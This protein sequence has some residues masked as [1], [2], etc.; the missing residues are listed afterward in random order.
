MKKFNILTALTFGLC[1]FGAS[2][3]QAAESADIIVTVSLAESI[4]VE[5]DTTAWNIGPISLGSSHE[6]NAFTATNKGNV[7]ADIKIKATDGA[8]GWIIAD[9]PGQDAFKVEVDRENDGVYD[10]T[11]TTID[12]DLSTNVAPN[13]TVNFKVKYSAPTSNTKPVGDDQGFKITITASKTP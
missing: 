13:N 4:S 10:L 7:N 11:L 8:G 1:L 3:I 12:Q 6:S 5:L 2:W 9:T